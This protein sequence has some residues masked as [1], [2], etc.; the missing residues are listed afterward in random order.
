MIHMSKKCILA[1][2]LAALLLSVC[3][4]LADTATVAADSLYMREGPDSATAV[5]KVLRNGNKLEVLGKKG[6]WYQVS[7]G[8]YSGYVYK[9]FV[10]ITEDGDDDVLQKGDKG[11]EV[12]QLQQ[13]LKELGY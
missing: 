3:T 8:K 5:V 13:R 10:V 1:A 6:N 4:A 11:A 12:K 2:L 7:F 9:D